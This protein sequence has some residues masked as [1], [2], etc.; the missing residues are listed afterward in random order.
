MES[1]ISAEA[2]NSGAGGAE[3]HAKWYLLYFLLAAL[4]VATVLASLTLNQLMMQI[5][6][7]SVATSQIWERRER[8]YATLAEL[9]RAVNAPGND[10]F[11]S[12]DVAA[13]AA[14]LRSALRA[15]DQ[16]MQATS[17]EIARNA[18]PAEAAPVLKAFDEIGQAMRE[19]VAEAELIF[20]Y[21]GTG[22]A[23]R[24]G[25]RMATMDRKYENVHQAFARLSAGIATIR[26]SHFQEHL[27]TATLLRRLEYL[28]LGL[29][30]LMVAGA[31][32]YGS[33]IYRN[34]RAAEAA[35]AGHMDALRRAR[36]EADAASSAKSKFL[37]VMSHEIRTPLN[38]MSLALDMLADPDSEE[39]KHQFLALGRSSERRLKRLIDDLIDLSRIEAG[40]VEFECMPFDLRRLLHELLGP[41]VERAAI[42]G[43]SLSI[44]FA[45]E[46]P[47]TV[48]G[49][50]TRFG[51]IVINLVDNAVKFTESGSI[52]VLVIARS[53]A[54]GAGAEQ[55]SVRLRVEVRD[56]G[57]GVPPDQCGRIFDDFVRGEES[58]SRKYGGAGLGLGVVRRLVE[59]MKG[60]V[61]VHATP[62]GGSTF[63]FEVELG[64][65]DAI[66]SPQPGPNAFPGTVLSGRRILLVEDDA[67]TRTVIAAVLRR[68]AADVDLAA[69][70]S[71]AVAAAAAARYD[72]ILMDIAMPVMDGF[73]ATLRIRE[74]EIG[75]AEVP[76]IALSAQA[77]EGILDRCLDAGMDD[78]LA[79]PVTR[80]S[81]LAALQR[82]ME[83]VTSRP[84]HLERGKP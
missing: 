21:F 30:V 54:A 63:W 59:L 79:K 6:V 74:R 52:V 23:E 10:V 11:D 34:A 81:V 76:I 60:Q 35:R 66:A 5:Y 22:Q 17:T 32:L 53:H 7:D 68:L 9:A 47:S 83:P 78:H 64:V 1:A 84:I 62:G 70:G 15:F 37:A 45:P 38:T 4:D 58:T 33:R 26:L 65:S 39:E 40:R 55:D 2:D 20:G 42:K 31:L 19:M 61:G 51:Q 56:T 41:H 71:E 82:W 12:R 43:V 36:A 16:Q 73:E 24:A 44:R 46:V 3:R 72:A 50:P 25:E 18:I 57:T 75:G 14:R 80:D 67:D 27:R 77:M 8:D 13:E 28:I 29:A 49:D 48:Q 69:D